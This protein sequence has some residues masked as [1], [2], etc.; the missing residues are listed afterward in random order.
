MLSGLF[1]PNIDKLERQQNVDA[2]DKCL[3]NK[4]EEIV[5]KAILALGRLNAKFSLYERQNRYDQIIKFLWDDRFKSEATEALRPA[6]SLF[7]EM[8]KS[9]D[10]CDAYS[11]RRSN[12]GNGYRYGST[13]YEVPT[14]P[15]IETLI[16]MGQPDDAADA[17]VKSLDDSGYY[18]DNLNTTKEEIFGDILIKI[19]KPSIKPLVERLQKIV[20]KGS[21]AGKEYKTIV[22]TLQAL[23]WRP[24]TTEDRIGMGDWPSLIKSGNYK[25]AAKAIDSLKYDEGKEM[26]DK[27]ALLGRPAAL[28]LIEFIKIN[29]HLSGSEIWDLSKVFRKIGDPAIELLQSSINDQVKLLKPENVGGKEQKFTKSCINILNQID[30][31]FSK[32]ALVALLKSGNEF[33]EWETA[34]CFKDAAAI[35][36]L[37]NYLKNNDP[38]NRRK[39]AESINKITD[40]PDVK[41]NDKTIDALIECLSD[42][43]TVDGGVYDDPDNWG[44]HKYKPVSREAESILSKISS[45][46]QK[47]K[48]ALEKH[49]QVAKD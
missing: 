27:V 12:N 33:V 43:Y 45:Y 10:R 20:S 38:Y 40:L 8:I 29:S 41:L 16:K 49:K 21:F 37:S 42:S 36:T 47:A 35:S 30:T 44:Q 4:D 26:M 24:E 6:I 5:K 46:S 14:K 13:I 32:K 22:K 7:K 48:I 39:A 1:K 11:I 17:L 34:I 18:Y 2:L 3:N 28:T 23:K 19:G 9:T 15:Y 25:E 31:P